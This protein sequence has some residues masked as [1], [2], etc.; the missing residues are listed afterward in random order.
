MRGDELDYDWKIP[1]R[2]RL[3]V[4]GQPH[5]YVVQI[6]NSTSRRILMALRYRDASFIL[7]HEINLIWHFC[8][9]A[10]A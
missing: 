6:D 4:G 3:P 1:D 5:L 10:F 7:Q 9:N 2:C 8:R